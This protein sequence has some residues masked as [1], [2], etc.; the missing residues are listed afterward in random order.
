MTVQIEVREETAVKLQAM[1]NAL[2]LSLDDYLT[3][4]AAYIPPPILPT[5]L[6]ID[7][8]FAMTFR[9][10]LSLNA[11]ERKA[12]ALD[13]QERYRDWIERELKSRRATWMI[14]L[15]GKIMES[16]PDLAD[17]P[18]PEQLLKLGKEH[19]LVPFVFSRPPLF[20]ELSWSAL[21]AGDFY[22]TLALTI[23]ANDWEHA[24]LLAQGQQLNADF[25]TGSPYLFLSW[26]WLLAAGLVEATPVDFPQAWH[27]LG[28]RYVYYTR[29]LRIGIAAEDGVTRSLPVACEC[30]EGWDQS[31]LGEVNPARLALAGRNLLLGF[32]LIVELNGKERK[33]VVAQC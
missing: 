33:T 16:S 29:L 22:P 8:A 25:D 9:D 2:Q 15:G 3:S 27:H 11:A 26:D 24:Q 23:G 17:Y 14:V 30:V 13:V 31:P 18:V 28:R 1:A 7:P 12:V 32:P 6:S 4:I 10:Y 19:D 5:P 21:S 20:E